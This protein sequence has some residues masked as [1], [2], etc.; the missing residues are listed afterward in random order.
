M[1]LVQGWIPNLRNGACSVD[2]TD[3]DCIRVLCSGG[4]W[5]SSVCILARGFAILLV[6]LLR[7]VKT[8]LRGHALCLFSLIGE[9][10][11]VSVRPI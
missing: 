4:C 2:V 1:H 9:Y 3:S 5:A 10:G 11:K 7:Q 6:L 8:F